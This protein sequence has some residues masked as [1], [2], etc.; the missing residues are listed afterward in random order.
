[1]NTTSSTISETAAQFE[2]RVARAIED[3]DRYQAKTIEQIHRLTAAG[4]EPGFCSDVRR[5][6]HSSGIR[7]ENIAETARMTAFALCDFLEGTADLTS[8]QLAAIVQLLGLQ[9][10]RPITATTS[11]WRKPGP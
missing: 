4:D 5:A 10:V 11:P 1:M 9:F 3:E 2:E 8:T 6:I 7:L